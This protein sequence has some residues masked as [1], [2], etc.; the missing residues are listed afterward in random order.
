MRRRPKVGARGTILRPDGNDGMAADW[1][2]AH[3]SL[4]V[5]RNPRGTMTSLV[6]FCYPDGAVSQLY[7]VHATRFI[8]LGR[9]IGFGGFLDEIDEPPGV[10]VGS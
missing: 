8:P 7:Y 5:F 2:R 6:R 9:G 10:K 4:M 3:G 1:D